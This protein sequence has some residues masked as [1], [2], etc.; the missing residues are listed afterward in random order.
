MTKRL[1][2][3]NLIVYT[4]LQVAYADESRVTHLNILT[5]FP[6]DFYTPFK[7]SFEDLEPGI[8]LDIRNKKTTAGIAFLQR[9]AP[10]D[11]DI[12]WASAPDAFSILAQ[13]DGN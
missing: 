5:S 7:Q 8:Q 6:P 2:A 10:T 4:L 3:F 9:Q 12:F 1:F 11:I 13:P